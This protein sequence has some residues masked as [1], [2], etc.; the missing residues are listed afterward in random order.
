M[1]IGQKSGQLDAGA[2]VIPVG[3]ATNA[4]GPFKGTETI[5]FEA[6]YVPESTTGP[7]KFIAFLIEYD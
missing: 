7:K 2:D 1:I 4:A 6:L 3:F 5:G